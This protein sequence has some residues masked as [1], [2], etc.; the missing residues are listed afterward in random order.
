MILFSEPA[1]VEP[2]GGT[3][4]LI[5]FCGFPGNLGKNFRSREGRGSVLL[6]F[7]STCANFSEDLDLDV[8]MKEQR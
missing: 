4:S 3:P 5:S 7:G 8:K 2:T 1:G 6:I